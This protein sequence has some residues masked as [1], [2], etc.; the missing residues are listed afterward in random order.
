MRGTA[1]NAGHTDT[2]INATKQNASAEALLDP[3]HHHTGS[4]YS[5]DDDKSQESWL[6]KGVRDMQVDSFIR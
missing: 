1:P 4:L 6:A 5:H 3:E 2:I